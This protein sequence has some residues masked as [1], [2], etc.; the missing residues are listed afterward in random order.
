MPAFDIL[1]TNYTTRIVANRV[2]S[3]HLL[4]LPIEFFFFYSNVKKKVASFYK[5]IIKVQYNLLFYLEIS[6][7]VSYIFIKKQYDINNENI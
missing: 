4:S 3:S 5:Y 2:V 6:F 1:A 7:Y